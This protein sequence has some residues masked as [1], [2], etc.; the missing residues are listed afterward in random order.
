MQGV[1]SRTTHTLVVSVAFLLALPGVAAGADFYVDAETGSD[2]GTTC[3]LATPCD[4]IAYAIAQSGTS[5]RILVDNGAYNESVTL[6]DGRSLEAQDFVADGSGPTVLDGGA[7][8]AISVPASGAGVIRGMTIRSEANPQVS[9]S[10]TV[11]ID[12][13]GFDD[14]DVTSTVGVQV[15]SGDGTNIHDN[16]F[17][18]P[19]PSD[20]RSR[21]AVY[22]PFT[23]VT[24][25]DNLIQNQNVGIQV[26]LVG[27]GQTLVVG[28]EIT[29]T[30]DLPFAGL[31]IIAGA[32]GGGTTIV[33][34]NEITDA[35]DSST[36]GVA[37]NSGLT[38]E[39]NEITGHNVGVD[40]ASNK[41]GITLFGDR[42]WGNSVGL[43]VA[44]SDS[45]LPKSSATAT[46]VTAVDNAADIFV[47][48]GALT[49]D[50][51]IVETMPFVGTAECTIAFS[52]ANT[53]GTDASGCNAFQTTADPAFVD[54]A[55]GDYHLTLGSPM[56]DI[57]NPADPP[58]GAVDFDGDPRAL[59]AEPTCTSNA[60]RRDMGADEFNR[61]P[62]DDCIP[63]ETTID[64]GPADG[65]YISSAS[66]TFTF[67]SEPTA[68]FECSADGEGFR[69]CSGAGED[70]LGPLAEGA[71]SFAVRATDEA[72][73]TDPT[74]AT[75]D[76]TVDMTDPES[77][78]TSGPKKR[79][80]KRTARLAWEGEDASPISFECSLD[81][82]AFAPCGTSKTYRR[83]KRGRHNFRVRGTDAADNLEQAP[84]VKRWRVVKRRR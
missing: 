49:L 22:S 32:S 48:S 56:I 55:N 50:S 1:G 52:R 34:G 51:S 38:L 78:I 7:S 20:S 8:A 54:A 31:S 3:P 6:G 67:S 62:P 25:R 27:P 35:A 28:N 71:H 59:A 53:I 57:G 45:G 73:N 72:L 58:A 37:A 5:D 23:P 36:N 81:G 60:G 68:T 11:E 30:H 41:T 4:T 46:N 47:S 2:T 80:K 61:G 19:A 84:A 15:N 70:A 66:P 69:A 39:R 76:F 21:L 16:T 29:G 17:V 9:V 79:T 13:N 77:T 12:S 64:T 65:S 26:G 63:P 83:L 42:I 18:D 40:I 14:P 43:R 75:R 44:D 74:P 10:G 82:A 24:I 33:R